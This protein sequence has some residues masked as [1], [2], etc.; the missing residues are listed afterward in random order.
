MD[1]RPIA[2][3]LG[4]IVLLAALLASACGGG[5][6]P[7]AGAHP[8]SEALARRL[9]QHARFWDQ[10]ESANQ[11]RLAADY[12]RAAALYRAALDERPDHEDAR[13]HLGNCAFELG[14]YEAALAAFE[15]LARR[16]PHSSRALAQIGRLHSMPPAP[17]LFDLAAAEAAFAAAHR[18]NREETGPALSL[19]EV[20]L[21]RGDL[22]RAR[23]ILEA[24]RST[25]PRAARAHFLCGYL[26]H[27]EGNAER[28]AADAARARAALEPLKPPPSA[29]SSEGDTQSPPPPIPTDSR[30]LL[31][32]FWVRLAETG[33]AAWPDFAEFD[34]FLRALRSELKSH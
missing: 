9:E 26:E 19:G 8:D 1:R 33:G 27:L 5:S 34:R 29:A 6:E 30:S 17:A 7:A 25:N 23:A 16:H 14:D 3:L 12:S 2:L 11:A 20:V 32:G 15:E 24:V 28:A 22:P 4:P 31:G 21:V 13:Y 10:L 18:I